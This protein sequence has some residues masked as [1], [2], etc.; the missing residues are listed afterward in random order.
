MVRATEGRSNGSNQISSGSSSRMC[1]PPGSHAAAAAAAAADQA[2]KNITGFLTR[3][4][5]DDSDQMHDACG[6]SE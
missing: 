1:I 5:Y 3:V 2:D 6:H 4:S